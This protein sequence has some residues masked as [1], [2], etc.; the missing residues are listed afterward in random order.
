[1]HRDFPRLYRNTGTG[2]FEDVGAEYDARMQHW[3]MILT[4]RDVHGGAWGDF[5]KDGDDDLIVGDEDEFFVNHADTG[6]HFE[7]DFTT[8]RQAFSAWIPSDDGSGLVSETRCQGNYVQLIDLDNDGDLDKICADSDIFPELRSDAEA[9]LVPAIGNVSDTIVGDFNNDLRQDII[10]IRGALRSI[11]ASKV[12]ATSIDAWFREGAGAQFTFRA[13]GK[14]TFLIDG[15]GGGAYMKADVL[16]LDTAGARSG[17]A[18]GIEISYDPGADLWTVLDNSDAED[19][20]QHHIRVRAENTV[21]E[22]MM[23]GQDARDLPAGIMHAVNL[24]NGFDW[25]Y[26]TGLRTP[27][28]CNSITTADFDNDMDLDLYVACGIGV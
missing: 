12:N 11:G 27:V 26:N 24:G 7:L 14:V 25:V 16:E 17:E 15:L 4:Q 3:W 18:R 2:D 1:G 22:P 20:D 9:D 28:Q 8:T 5:D 13:N 6:G 23:T 10:A 19:N 21:S